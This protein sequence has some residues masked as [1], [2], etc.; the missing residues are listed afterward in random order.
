MTIITD[1][2]SETTA[3]FQSSI[4]VFSH[5]LSDKALFSD[6]ALIDL[7]TNHPTHLTD[8]CTMSRSKNPQYPHRLRT[9]DFRD[10][11]P[12]ELFEAAVSGKIWINLRKAMNIHSP[13]AALLTNMYKEI[14]AHTRQKPFNANGGILITSPVA[15]TPYHF[16][17]TETIL[18][19]IRGPKRIFIYPVNP[20]FIPDES[21]ESAV[22]NMAHDDLPYKAEFDAEATIINLQEGQAVSWPLS[23]PHRVENSGLCVSVTTEFSSRESGLKNAAMIANAT[24]RQK[25]GITPSWT[26]E[27]HLNR[28][29]KSALGIM[30]KKTNLAVI[31]KQT[32]FVTFKVDPNIDGSILD[33]KPF[34]RNF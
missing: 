6:A 32:D 10:C 33:I 13:Y 9:G 22:T 4:V 27:S 28:L 14:A 11:S 15:R 17:K 31:S 12:E 5:N 21:Y 29:I 1:W 19:H 20:K 25:F 18:W 8:V 7:I 23:S 2:T 26:K 30:L 34:K 16:D 3:A 24:L